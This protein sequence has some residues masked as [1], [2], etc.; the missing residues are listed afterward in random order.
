VCAE[1]CKHG[2]GRGGEN[3]AELLE[4][5][6]TSIPQHLA[7]RLLYSSTVI[8]AYAEEVDSHLKAL[9]E[10]ARE[11]AIDLEQNCVLLAVFRLHGSMQLVEPEVTVSVAKQPTLTSSLT[12]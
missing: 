10:L 7:C 8:R 4:P 1:R 12:L 5:D 3:R 9:L 11:I 6:K 2:S